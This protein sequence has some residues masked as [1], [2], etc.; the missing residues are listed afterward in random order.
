MTRLNHVNLAVSNVPELT[1]FFQ[2]AF[3]F[4]L[5]AQRGVGTFSVLVGDDGFALVLSH[6]KSV[7]QD[8]YPKLFHVGFLVAS[9][10]EVRQ[11]H[12]RITDAGFDAPVPAILRRGGSPTYGFYCHAP[13]GVMVEVSSR[14]D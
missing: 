12:Q 7:D 4:R 14:A 13:G 5:V 3:G 6:D 10:E 2:Q 9:A 8:T 1:R 11:Q